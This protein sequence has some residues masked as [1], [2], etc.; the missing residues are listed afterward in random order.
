MRHAWLW[1]GLMLSL[2][3]VG[4]RLGCERGP[5]KPDNEYC[6]LPNDT[7]CQDGRWTTCGQ[8]SVALCN[9]GHACATL[10][11]AD[12]AACRVLEGCLVPAPGCWAN[13]SLVNCFCATPDCSGRLIGRCV[14]QLEALAHTT[15]AATLIRLLNDR[16]STFTAIGAELA[17]S[18]GAGCGPFCA[19]TEP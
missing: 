16:T 11:L 6:E 14:P 7:Y 19:D 18:D 15:E 10:T 4:D 9:L 8:C 3:G 12:E 13:G 5:S 17:C 1:T 2:G